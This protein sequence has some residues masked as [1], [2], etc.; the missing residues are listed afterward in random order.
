MLDQRELSPECV[1][2]ATEALQFDQAVGA[3]VQ[4]PEQ[5]HLVRVVV[6]E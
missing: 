3:L 4:H 6:C 5:Q 2:L 1:D